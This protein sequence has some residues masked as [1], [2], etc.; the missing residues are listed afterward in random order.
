MPW[1]PFIDIFYGIGYYHGIF[2][3]RQIFKR[4]FF[5]QAFAIWQNAFPSIGVVIE[6]K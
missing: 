2:L 4:I 1:F 5:L 6:K 3:N